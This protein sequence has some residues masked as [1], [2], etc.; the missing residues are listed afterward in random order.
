ISPG[1]YSFVDAGGGSQRANAWAPL[2][3]GVSAASLFLEQAEQNEHTDET[4]RDILT[5]VVHFLRAYHY[6][7]LAFMYGGF[8]I[9]DKPYTLSDEFLVARNTF[10][11][12]IDFIV[13]ECD[14]AAALLPLEQ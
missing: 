14:K 2:Y 4:L 10:K 3:R 9:I 6:H 12:C 11:E 13:S 1:D 8:P 7:I 5:G